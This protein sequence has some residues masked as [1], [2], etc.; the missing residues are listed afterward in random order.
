MRLNL[1]IGPEHAPERGL[2]NESERKRFV[3]LS[4]LLVMV[5][6]MFVWSWFK[7]ARK[8]GSTAADAPKIEA[9]RVELVLP[10]IDAGS[11]RAKTADATPEERVILETP[12]LEEILR[13][14]RL[15]GPDHF[16]PMGG[17]ALTPEVAAELEAD[18]AAHRGELFRA[19]GVIEAI[20]AFDGAGSG[21]SAHYRGRL[22]LEGGG[23]AGFAVLALP[24]DWGQVGHF[25]RLEGLFLK[26]YREQA[27]GSWVEAPFLVGRRLDRAY[28]DLGEVGPLDRM[29]FQDVGDDS[30]TEI[31]GLPF[32][33]YWM[34]V[35]S[36]R[37]M[38][39]D[40]VDWEAAPLLDAKA[41][42]EVFEYGKVWRGAPFRI[43]PSE[44]QAI[45][46]QAQ[47]ENPARI[48]RM[49]EG[50]AGNWDWMRN[51]V[52]VI[53]FVCPVDST[54]LRQKDWFTARGFF[55]KNLAYEPRDGGIAVAPYF[56]I[57]SFEPFTPPEPASLGGV[58][59]LIAVGLILLGGAIFF[60]LVRDRRKTAELQEELRRRR[61]ARRAA[62]P[63]QT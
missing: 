44:I 60:A 61:R 17:R 38:A 55:L 29:V 20:E 36:A 18:S 49:V 53:R 7:G 1:P 4:V 50:W 45:W 58:F 37:D 52:G 63:Q 12:A 51:S 54:G 23:S 3:M 6:G 8:L 21:A 19:Y 22:R 35:A 14:S 34:L 59:A 32:E 42:T 62:Q 31:T 30:A 10:T 15:I 13:V 46:H 47:P 16:E 27:G 56:V 33:P 28:P 25:A 9:P 48:G 24:D 2:F 57:H 11:L 5:L 43:P 40:T 41:L 26:Q 39:E